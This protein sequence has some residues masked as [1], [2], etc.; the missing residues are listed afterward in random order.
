MRLAALALLLVAA[1]SDNASEWERSGDTAFAVA[2]VGTVDMTETGRA[3]KRLL[4]A[5][6]E[7]GALRIHFRAD[8]QDQLSDPAEI[9]LYVLTYS[10]EDLAA[11]SLEELNVWQIVDL[12]NGIEIESG[13]G[14][15]LIMKGCTVHPRLCNRF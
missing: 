8:G 7:A 11:A 15:S 2:T 10:G 5:A 1:C 4:L 9:P 13:L 14:R 6:P 12:A 3:A